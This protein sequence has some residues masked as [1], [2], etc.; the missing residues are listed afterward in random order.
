MEDKF[1]GY[2]STKLS[3]YIIFN[4]IYNDYSDEPFIFDTT[5]IE[6]LKEAI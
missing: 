2:R 3:L 1:I 6:C 5:I 4:E